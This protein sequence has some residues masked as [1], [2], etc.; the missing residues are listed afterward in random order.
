MVSVFEIFKIGIG[1]SSSH[2]VGPMK[3]GDYEVNF[4]LETA[5]RFQAENL[6]LH[7]NGMTIRAYQQQT[8]LHSKTYYSIGG[9]FVV[10]Q[11]HFGKALVTEETA[12]YPFYS[13]Q[14]LLQH[15][16][17]HCLSLSAIVM[18]NEI[19][20]HERELSSTTLPTC[21]KPCKTPSIAA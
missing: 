17:D 6:P 5:L 15:C 4:P 14:K 13:A 12:P 9:G 11:E 18:R 19:A 2:T 10:D 21:G 1:Q 7:E 8:L 3:A 20:L 16:H